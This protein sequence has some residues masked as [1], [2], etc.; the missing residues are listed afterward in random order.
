MLLEWAML[1]TAVTC[2]LQPR[3]VTAARWRLWRTMQARQ[4]DGPFS[5]FKERL[6]AFWASTGDG[7]RGAVRALQ[8]TVK[9]QGDQN[10]FQVLKARMEQIFTLRILTLVVCMM[11]CLHT[12]IVL[13][14]WRQRTRR[15]SE[16]LQQEA[17]RT[18]EKHVKKPLFRKLKSGWRKFPL[19]SKLK[20]LKISRVKRKLNIKQYSLKREVRNLRNLVKKTK[21]QDFGTTEEQQIMKDLNSYMA[22][23]REKTYTKLLKVVMQEVMRLFLV[24]KMRTLRKKLGLQVKTSGGIKH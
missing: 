24:L 6:L 5:S 16:M 8:L 2:L 12:G 20:G 13:L 7:W 4:A 15:Q 11:W 23:T 17:K 22:R 1:A 21:P 14:L 3:A 18:D 9:G 10:C 19:R